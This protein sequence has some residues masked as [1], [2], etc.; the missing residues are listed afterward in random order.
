[1]TAIADRI[2]DPSLASLTLV[3][4]L[5]ATTAYVEGSALPAPAAVSDDGSRIE[6]VQPF[7]P[8]SGSSFMLALRPSKL[9]FQPAF[10]SAEASARDR[11]GLEF[12]A[13][14]PMSYVAVFGFL[15]Q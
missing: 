11:A 7:P 15:P 1:M 12:S 9:G 3:V 6:W 8:V 14:A 10:L 13:I 2:R 5:P 4:E